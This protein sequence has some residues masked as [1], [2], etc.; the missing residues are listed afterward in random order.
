MHILHEDC[1]LKRRDILHLPIQLLP[2]IFRIFLSLIYWWKITQSRMCKRRT[3]IF[4]VWFYWLIMLSLMNLMQSGIL[5]LWK[6]S[7]L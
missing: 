3:N 4:L 5:S 1:Y 6:R 7:Y 2:N